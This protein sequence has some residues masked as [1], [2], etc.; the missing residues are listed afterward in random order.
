MRRGATRDANVTGTGTDWQAVD[1]RAQARRVQN[2]RSCI[3]RATQAGDWKRVGALQ[4][5]MLRSQANRLVSVHH[6]MQVVQGKRTPGN[7]KMLVKTPAA[8]G[9][10]A[11][12]L[13][14]YHPWRAQPTRRVYIPKANGQQRT[15]GIPTIADRA[16]QA[17]VRNALEPRWEARLEGSSYGF[18]PGRSAYDAIAKIYPPASPN[19]RK[20]WVVD[21]DIQG[22][23]DYID[24]DYLLRTIGNFPRRH[25]CANGSKPVTWTDGPSTRPRREPPKV[26]SSAYCSQHRPAWHGA[27][28]GRETPKRA[29]SQ[30]SRRGALRRRLRGIL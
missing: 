20:Q 9:R 2:L 26:A 5:L 16:L 12:T 18:R 28:A 15:Q 21:A 19:K 6:V 17:M 22:A 7:D 11:D 10:R 3:Y 25:W 29:N 1:W 24:H 8:H 27:G 23:F 13:T 4:K 30:C 14:T